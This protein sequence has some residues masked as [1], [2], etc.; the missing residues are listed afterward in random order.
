MKFLNL[1]FLVTVLAFSAAQ[2]GEHP[3]QLLGKRFIALIGD[4][5]G[6]AEIMSP[7]CEQAIDELYDEAYTV[8]KDGRRIFNSREGFKKEIKLV[9]KDNG[10]WSV[11][12]VEY[13][14]D[15]TDPKHCGMKFRL[16]IVA[17]RSFVI[18]ADLHTTEDGKRIASL[19]ETVK[20]V[21]EPSAS[22]TK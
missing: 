3:A 20:S 18:A 16:N 6:R 5:F 15:E 12:Q 9:K 1:S 7:G 21:G 4:R 11:S 22:V 19:R 13:T 14:P 8:V 17:G 10:F 2:A